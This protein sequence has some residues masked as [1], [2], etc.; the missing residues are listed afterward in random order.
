M[1]HGQ[2]QTCWPFSLQARNRAEASPPFVRSIE[3][4][5][6]PTLQTYSHDCIPD[7]QER[8]EARRVKRHDCSCPRTVCCNATPRATTT[9]ETKRGSGRLQATT[10]RELRLV[11]TLEREIRYEQSRK[12]NAYINLA[13][14]GEKNL[15]SE[16]NDLN[17]RRYPYVK[18]HSGI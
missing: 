3:K 1:Q 11:C 15:L 13:S 12:L 7:D 18:S 10:E 9:R 4:R 2:E 17:H 6:I 14:A 16:T 5:F 8:L